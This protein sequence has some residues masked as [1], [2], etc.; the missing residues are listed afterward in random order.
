M[1]PIVEAT[2]GVYQPYALRVELAAACALL[3]AFA[4]ARHV[5]AIS[6]RAALA[7]LAALGTLSLVRL[8]AL[9]RF[10]KGGPALV[11]V[12][13][14]MLIFTRPDDSRGTLQFALDELAQVVVYGTRSRRRF[15]F[16]RKDGTVTEAVPIWGRHV[17]DAVERFLLRRLSDELEI[18][19]AAPQSWFAGI[20]GDYP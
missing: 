7:C 20:R 8:S 17:N 10:G 19:V 11:A 15:R 2:D 4:L 9:R 5:D 6:P 3:L 18:T 13:D 12:R 16:V 1:R 14:G